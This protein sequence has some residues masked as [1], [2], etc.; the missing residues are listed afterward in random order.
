MDLDYDVIIIGSGPAGLTAGLY[1]SRARLITLILERETLG[2]ELMN[3][4][5]IENYPGFDEGIMGPDLGSQMLNQV[6]ALGTKIEF[7]EVNGLAITGDQKIVSTAQGEFWGRGVIIAGGAHPKKLG[8]PGEDD[9][10]HR[11][12]FSCATCDGPSYANKVVAVAGG[13]DSGVT[14]ALILARMCSKVYLL[15]LLSR[16]TAS[17]VLQERVKENP[18]I[19]V[20]CGTQITA[21]R[22]QEQVE[23]IDII[24]GPGG[25]QSSLAVTGVLMHIGIEPNSDYL[26]GI[27]LLNEQGQVIVNEWMATGVPG[28]FAAGDIRANSS[29]QISTAVGDG[30]TAAM[31]LIRYLNKH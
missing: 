10:A 30:A 22:G 28:V 19:E 15:E 16:L 13:G 25:E 29:Q 3:R 4:E 8:V 24:K 2:G 21:I 7:T 18:A 12:V 6:M 26:K 11:G 1:T 17:Q 5:T 9:F 20:L 27:I 23:S 31:T 14:E